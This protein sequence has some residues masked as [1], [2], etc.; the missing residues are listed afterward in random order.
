VRPKEARNHNNQF[1]TRLLPSDGL[2]KKEIDRHRDFLKGI[3]I[4]TSHLKPVIWLTREDE[5]FAESFFQANSLDPKQ[6]VLS[7]CILVGHRSQLLMLVNCRRRISYRLRRSRGNVLLALGIDNKTGV[8][9][10]LHKQS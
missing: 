1:Y 3:G 8:R 9:S 7:R 6:K 2:Y 10:R 4:E 5:Q